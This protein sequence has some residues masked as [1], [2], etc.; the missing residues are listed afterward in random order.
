MENW[1]F[2]ITLYLEKIT[3][4]RG[5]FSHIAHTNIEPYRVNKAFQIL[6]DSH[7]VDERYSRE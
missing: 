4:L 1:N 2:V 7:P 5:V 6:I 3:I